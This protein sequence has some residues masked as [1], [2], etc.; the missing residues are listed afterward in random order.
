MVL[1]ANETPVSFL[2]IRSAE[3]CNPGAASHAPAHVYQP[4]VN[5]F[6][7]F[8]GDNAP[9]TVSEEMGTVLITVVPL[10]FGLDLVSVAGR[11]VVGEWYKIRP[12]L[13]SHYTVTMKSATLTAFVFAL[14]ATCSRVRV[15][16]RWG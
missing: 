5:S 13:L 11:A 6:L 7:Y 1:L 15:V 10:T 8:P 9:P 4:A 2:D 12:S 3:S 14:L 16:Q